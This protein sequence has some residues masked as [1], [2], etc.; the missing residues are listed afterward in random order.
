MQ[1]QVVRKVLE[2]NEETA[3]Q[4]RDTFSRHR[5][6][7]LNLMS[8][9]GAGKTTLLETTLGTLQ[10]SFN[11]AVI[12]GDISTTRDAERIAA[13]G[14]QTLQI[15]TDGACHLDSSMVLQAL[16]HLDLSSLDLLF[17]ENVG[18]LVCPAEFELGE[19]ATITLLSIPEGDDKPEK[20]PGMFAKSHALI[21]NKT[22]LLPYLTFDV[23]RAKTAAMTV[24]KDLEFFAVSA[25][26]GDGLEEWTQWIADKVRD[27]KASG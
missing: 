14:A 20:Y 27:K 8:S 3:K 19:D 18:N 5:T 24:N 13:T 11:T 15:N 12:E 25:A 2:H 6:L 9:P 26:Q 1:I 21:L 4:L 16:E 10:R 22:D 7:V 23:E 17:I